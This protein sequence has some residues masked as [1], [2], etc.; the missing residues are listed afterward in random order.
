MYED[1]RGEEERGMKGE[2]CCR[3]DEIGEEEKG[4]KGEDAVEEMT[5]YG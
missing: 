4:M 5:V 3:G 1:E 2:G